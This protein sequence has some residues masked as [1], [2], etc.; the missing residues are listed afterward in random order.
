MGG[1]RI[2]RAARGADDGRHV[3]RREGEYW[4]L[5]YD[6]AICR[7][8]DS[9]GLQHIG[10]L[11]RHPGQHFDARELVVESGGPGATADRFAAAQLASDGLAV[12]GLGD[13]GAVLDATAKA[14]YKRRVAELREELE[15]AE[16]FND[17]GRAAAAREELDF[18][19][20]Q[21]SAAVGL[22]GRDRKAASSDERARLTVTKRI[23]DALGKIRESHAQ[24]G[25]YLAAHI[26]TG[27]L[28]A[29]LPDPDRPI[30]WTS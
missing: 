11:L 13:A 8:R 1:R 28:C 19:A 25:Q 18:I 26:K 23:K 5:A 3:F 2:G 17:R 6:G 24:L 29:Y 4:T 12:A 22:G 10:H 21:L 16:E 7:L 30:P 9:K 20:S 14:A 15:E 27:Y